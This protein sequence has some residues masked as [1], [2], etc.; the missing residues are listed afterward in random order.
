MNSPIHVL[1]AGDR[2]YSPFLLEGLTNKSF[3]EMPDGQLLNRTLRAIVDARYVKVLVVV[4]P[5]LLRPRIPRSLNGIRTVFIE[6]RDSFS[7][8]VSVALQWV[9]QHYPSSSAIFITNDAPLLTSGELD[10]FA[11]VVESDHAAINIAVARVPEADLQ[12]SLV[13]QYIRSIVTLSDGPYLIANQVSLTPAVIEIIST[14][15]A[16]FDLRKQSRLKTSGRTLIYALRQSK[17]LK[18]VMMWL[19]LI[20]AKRVWLRKPRS[21]VVSKVALPVAAIESG[22][23]EFIGHNLRVRITEIPDSMG[24]FDADTQEQLEELRKVITT[25]PQFKPK[26]AHA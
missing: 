1:L 26:A 10:R 16:L 22:L 14:I 19:R 12:S 3:L 15:Q 23:E 5:E 7:E 21:Q 6:Q 13:R 2:E 17:N 9:Q 8:N 25:Q 20:V 18:I 24:C 11:S 4:G